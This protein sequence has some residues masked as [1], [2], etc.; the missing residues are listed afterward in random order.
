MRIMWIC[1]GLLPEAY[2]ALGMQDPR[3]N[4]GFM[5]SAF[6]AIKSRNVENQLCVLSWD[7][8]KCDVVVGNARHISFGGRFKETIK[9]VPIKYCLIAQKVIKEFAPDII[10]ILGTEGIFAHLPKWVFDGRKTVVSMQGV[11]SACALNYAGG[12]TRKDLRN[13]WFNCSFIR[14]GTSLS[15]DMRYWR[16]VR[17]RLEADTIRRHNNFIGRTNF[18]LSWVHYYNPH[19][20]YYLVNESMRPEFY[21]N[22]SRRKDGVRRHSIFCGGAAGYPLKGLH[23]AL[24]ALVAIK[25]K[26]PDVQ[27]RVAN[28]IGLSGRISPGNYLRMGYYSLYLRRLIRELGLENAICCLPKLS[29]R[30]VCEELRSAEIFV[31]PSFCENSPNSLSEAMLIGTP[32][33]AMDVGGVASM[34][35][36]NV[37]GRLVPSGDPAQ[38]AQAIENWFENKEFAL[39]CAARARTQA[40]ARH[41]PIKNAEVLLQ[42][43]NKIVENVYK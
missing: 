40:L 38:L 8:R 1:G 33:I 13:T 30:E 35:T 2:G 21:N 16:E 25:K 20:N 9:G 26:Y 12:L 39:Q 5:G 22:I 11:I 10:H 19:A 31:L 37:S 32:A 6:A 41:D 43:Y 7:A 36:D 34:L 42:T 4:G 15:S 18:D 29:A 23:L 24:R 3:I 27:L 28:A 17:A 14:H